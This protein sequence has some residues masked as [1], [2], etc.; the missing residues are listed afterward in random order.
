ML[1]LPVLSASASSPRPG[2]PPPA[3]ELGPQRGSL[4]SAGPKGVGCPPQSRP[5]EAPQSSSSRGAGCEWQRLPC[6]FVAENTT[7]EKASLS[8]SPWHI[9]LGVKG[10]TGKGSGDPFQCSCPG[11]PMDRGHATVPGVARVGHDLVTEP[12]LPKAAAGKPGTREGSTSQES[13]TQPESVQKLPL[14]Q[15]LHVEPLD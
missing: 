1:C 8:P 6:L 10:M 3:W 15:G 2:L 5:V 11:N 4:S 14:R 12:T 9:S 13:R 7:E